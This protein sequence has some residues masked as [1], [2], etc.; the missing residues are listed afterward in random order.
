M[1]ADWLEPSLPPWEIYQFPGRVSNTP[2]IPV[3]ACPG[4]NSV[5]SANFSKGVRV[6]IQYWIFTLTPLQ[7]F[8]QP[9]FIGRSDRSR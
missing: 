8:A 4:W 6:N 9:R 1:A 5:S 2:R 7:A 3:P